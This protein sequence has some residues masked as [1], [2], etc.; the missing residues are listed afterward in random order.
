MDRVF[1]LGACSCK[2]FVSHYDSLFEEIGNLN[3]IKGGSGCGKST[4]MKALGKAAEERGYEVSYI[5]CSSDPDSLDGVLIP[6]LSVGYVD[7]T[8]PHV[9]EPLICAGSANYLNFG[10]F[11]DREGIKANEG[12]IHSFR[13]RNQACYLL[14]HSCLKAMDALTE[15]VKS[16]TQGSDYDEE[17]QAIGECLCLSALKPKW[18]T[19]KLL[20]RFLSALTPKGVKVLSSTPM[21]LC[22]KVY[23]LQDHYALA[24]R[25]L[26]QVL[27]NALSQGYDCIAGYSPLQPEGSPPYLLIP[28]AA[29]AFVSHSRLFPYEGESF[30]RIDLDSTLPPK[31]RKDLSY[32]EPACHSLLEHCLSHLKQAKA[33]HDHMEELCKPFV[34]FSAVTAL[35]QQTITQI[36]P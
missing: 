2:G 28:E 20:R 9:L 16:Q 26:D 15:G 6:K 17:L 13:K 19:G 24:P 32:V 27:K 14:A 8:A 35:T 36:F 5:L 18:G 11:Y 12:E 31:L 23:V 10:S 30:C 29:V 25:V 34:N 33:Y 4:F 3:I 1:F 21:S 7:G 22:S